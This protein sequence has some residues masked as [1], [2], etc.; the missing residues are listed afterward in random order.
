MQFSRSDVAAAQ[1]C[2]LK[3]HNFMYGK[4]FWE[5]AKEPLLEKESGCTLT[6]Q[7]VTKSPHVP[8]PGIVFTILLNFHIAFPKY[9]LKIVSK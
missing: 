3:P 4:D 8:F 7:I 6:Y 2:E 5:L 9:F 1:K